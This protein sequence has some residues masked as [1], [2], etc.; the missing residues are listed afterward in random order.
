MFDQLSC[1]HQLQNGM[2][3][4][5]LPTTG[6]SPVSNRERMSAKTSNS[7]LCRG[8]SRYRTA[9]LHLQNC[10]G[11]KEPPHSSRQVNTSH[12]ASFAKDFCRTCP[13]H[14]EPA[15]PRLGCI[16]VSSNSAIFSEPNTS[17]YTTYENNRTRLWNRNRPVNCRN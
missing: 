8:S 5:M 17:N 12:F 4:D 10:S 2:A 9:S 16:V 15:D 6:E 13:F 14:W 7:S 11:T 1:G 3:K